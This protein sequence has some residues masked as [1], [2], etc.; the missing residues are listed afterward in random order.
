MLLQKNP[1]E[2]QDST[3]SFLQ[4]SVPSAEGLGVLRLLW[5][6]LLFPYGTKGTHRC[7]SMAQ[8]HRVM[9]WLLQGS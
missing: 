7:E 9:T 4:S 2:R 3:R 6:V 8:E 5:P 1:T